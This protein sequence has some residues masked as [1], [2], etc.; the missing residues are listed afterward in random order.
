MVHV[1]LV[2]MPEMVQFQIRDLVQIFIHVIRRQI[3]QHLSIIIL[4]KNLLEKIVR[5]RMWLHLHARNRPIKCFRGLLT[6]FSLTDQRNNLTPEDH[7]LVQLGPTG[8][9][10]LRHANSFVLHKRVREILR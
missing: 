3:A 10:E 7:H 4:R 6:R 2:A 8:D 9:D 5:K 1:A